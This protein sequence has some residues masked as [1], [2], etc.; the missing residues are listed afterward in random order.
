MMCNIGIILSGGNGTRFGSQVPKQYLKL[1]GK[2]VIEYSIEAFQRSKLCDE[3][4]IVSNSREVISGAT[5][6][7]G[8][9]SR[10]ISLHNALQYIKRKHLHCRKV[11]INEAARPFVTSKLIDDYFMLLDDYEA[12]ITTKR[13]TDSLG[14]EGERVTDRNEYYLIAAPEAFRFPLLAENFDPA[15]AITATVQQLPAGIKV[16]RY[17]NFP[18]NYKITYPEDL[19]IAEQLIK[20]N[21]RWI[22]S[23]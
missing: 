6:V 22:K 1:C 4:I 13:I 9:K 12:V 23:N 16:K 19:R 20:E 5:Y 3:L 14:R 8:G 15:S 17:Y 21:R 2:Q 10:N 18:I 7:D 11:V